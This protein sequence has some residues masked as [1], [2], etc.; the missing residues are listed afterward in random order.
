MSKT[1][2]FRL[3]RQVFV[4]PNGAYISSNASVNAS[5]YL[6]FELLCRLCATSFTILSSYSFIGHYMFRFNWPSSGVQVVMVK[7]SAT[8]CSAVF[9][10]PNVVASGETGC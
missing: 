3:I 7:D 6:T 1:A 8:H 9:F 4:R 2:K 10:P 5:V